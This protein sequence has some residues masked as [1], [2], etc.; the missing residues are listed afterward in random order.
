M[1]YPAASSETDRPSLRLVGTDGNAFSILGRAHRALRA[2]GRADE[3]PA[4]DAEATA[5][6]YDALLRVTMEWFEV[7]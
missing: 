7:E 4:F 2:A 3:I 5:G 1:S 6:D